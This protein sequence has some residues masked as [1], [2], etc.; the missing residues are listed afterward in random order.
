VERLRPLCGE[1]YA[2]GNC[3][4]AGT[5]MKATRDGFDAAVNMGL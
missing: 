1:F 5:I 4:K 3:V 2:V